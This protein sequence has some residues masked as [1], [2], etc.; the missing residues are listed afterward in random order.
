MQSLGSLAERP[1]TRNQ[2]DLLLEMASRK[3]PVPISEFPD[4]VDD[5]RE[6]ISRGFLRLRIAAFPWGAEFELECTR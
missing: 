1:L 5:I 4:R 3:E 6:L 2:E